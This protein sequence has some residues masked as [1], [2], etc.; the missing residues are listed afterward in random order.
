MQIVKQRS[1]AECGGLL[2]IDRHAGEVEFGADRFSVM[3]TAQWGLGADRL[4]MHYS[5]I[6]KLLA[7]PQFKT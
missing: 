5:T 3:A 7:M 4:G 1:R 6:S 2:A